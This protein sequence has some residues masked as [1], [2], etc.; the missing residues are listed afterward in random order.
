MKYLKMLA[1]AAVAAG[2]L[3]AFIGAGTASASKL[4]STTVSPCPGG[5]AWSTLSLEWSLVPGTSASHQE[6]EP[7]EGEGGT[8]DT[9]SSSTVSGEITNSGSSTAT[10]T[11]SITSLTWGTCTFAT[12]TTM[13]GK[14]EIHNI[15]GT[16]NGTLT[17]D[18]ET[19]WTINTILFGTCTWGLENGK[20]MGDITEGNP[21]ILHMNAVADKKEGHVFCP[22]K[23][24]WT[25]TYTL[26]KPSGT[27]LA[28]TPS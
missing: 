20:S 1:L 13:K 17:S 23:T 2:A 15:P 26:T 11:G 16:F 14:F 27:T 22:T 8:V 5:Q 24:R 21:A 12:A 28:I 7:P 19:R 4:C 9:C 25:G 6:L 18:G 10:A 3:M